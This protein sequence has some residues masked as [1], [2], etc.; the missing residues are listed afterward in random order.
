M[1]GLLL[2]STQTGQFIDIQRA[3]VPPD[4]EFMAYNLRFLGAPSKDFDRLLAH[5]DLTD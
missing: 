5:H 4:T 1:S 3:F 2:L